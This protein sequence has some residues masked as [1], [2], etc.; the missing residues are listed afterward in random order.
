MDGETLTRKPETEKDKPFSGK[1]DCGPRSLLKVAPELDP[2]EVREAFVLSS[3]NWPYG[4]VTNREFAISMRF[5]SMNGKLSRKYEYRSE[6]ESLADLLN[7]NPARC[8][9]LLKRHFIAI[10][11]GEVVGRELLLKPHEKTEVVCSWTF[12]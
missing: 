10:L 9:A 11:D 3:E 8:V 5:L 7:R 1:H 2:E 4:G 12:S 6:T